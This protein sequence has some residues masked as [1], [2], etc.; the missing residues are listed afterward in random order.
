MN[1]DQLHQAIVYAF[2]EE[3][4]AAHQEHDAV[5][6]RNHQEAAACHARRRQALN[7]AGAMIER[8]KAEE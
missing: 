2:R 1:R 5:L 7:R 4:V 3:R 8:L 6:A